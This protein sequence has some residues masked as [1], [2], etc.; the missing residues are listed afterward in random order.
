MALAEEWIKQP[1]SER[2]QPLKGMRS[3]DNL[4]IHEIYASMQGEST[5]AGYPCVFIR[6]TTCHLRCHYCDTANAFMAGQEMTIPDILQKVRSFGISH[7]ELT[8]GEPLLQKASFELLTQLCDAGFTVLLETSGAICIQ[9][10]DRRVHVVLDIKTPGSG[11]STRMNWSNLETLWPGCE[12]KFVICSRLDYDFAKQICEKY[13][14]FAKGP[15][16][17]SPEAT[18]M[19]KALL[20]QWMI[21]DRLPAKFQ[22]QLHKALWGD[23]AG[24]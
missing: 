3:K 6:T 22:L 21:E 19:D 24:V 1:L 14:L 10:I 18:H 16:L 23:K 4:L 17:F 15:V 2:I 5:F 8:G 13:G 20:A 9:K 12:V 7:V 11:E